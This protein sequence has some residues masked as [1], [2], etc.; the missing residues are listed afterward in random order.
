MYAPAIFHPTYMLM[1]MPLPLCCWTRYHVHRIR[2]ARVMHRRPP[3]LG[4]KVL[5]AATTTFYQISR[6]RFVQWC[7]A[8]PPLFTRIKLHATF[9]TH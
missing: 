3:Q 8:Y 6:S 4:E 5:S 9:L 1:M 2:I 7:A